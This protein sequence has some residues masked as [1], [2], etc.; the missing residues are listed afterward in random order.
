VTY[1]SYYWTL[2]LELMIVAWAAV[3]ALGAVISFVGLRLY[4]KTG[5]R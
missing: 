2:P 4:R 5:E 3:I 1:D